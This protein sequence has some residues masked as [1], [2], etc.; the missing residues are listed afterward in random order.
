MTFLA[1]QLRFENYR[2]WD[3]Q[4]AKIPIII[5]RGD[6]K[7]GL[8]SISLQYLLRK[9]RP[10]FLYSYSGIKLE[11]YSWKGFLKLYPK[12][13]YFG[14]RQYYLKNS[15]DSWFD[16][17][18]L[19]LQMR[20]FDEKK[21]KWKGLAK[22]F[23]YIET[24]QLRNIW[25]ELVQAGWNIRIKEALVE[26][27]LLAKGGIYFNSLVIR[28]KNFTLTASRPSTNGFGKGGEFQL[29]LKPGRGSI[30][31]R[32]IELKGRFASSLNYF[33]V[34]LTGFEGRLSL[35]TNKDGGHQL[36]L[37]NIDLNEYFELPKL[38][39]LSANFVL[40]RDYEL[41]PEMWMMDS[42]IVSAKDE[43]FY[44]KP[45]LFLE[46]NKEAESSIY[47]VTVNGKNKDNSKELDWIWE[48]QYMPQE[49][50]P[51][52]K[53]I[54]SAKAQNKIAITKK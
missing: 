47:R 38:K 12:F 26:D 32:K 20:D 30:F 23:A 35:R 40:G 42:A 14:Y 6:I 44:L 51:K 43:T 1:T 48:S 54:G 7:L 31:K 50:V 45:K 29:I 21:I 9:H 3:N 17:S 46:K 8:D 49:E 11:L 24:I 52:Y 53:L 41:S 16:D 15:I 4:F 34:A 25:M 10:N 22:I 5:D 19:N 13:K 2:A 27:F 36:N 39:I 33:R 18:E 28:G 37:K